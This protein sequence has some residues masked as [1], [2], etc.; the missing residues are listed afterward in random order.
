MSADMTI[1]EAQA[2]YRQR[3]ESFIMPKRKPKKVER[4][5]GF[6]DNAAD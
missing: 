6:S 1:A 5:S 4:G 3:R 2:Y